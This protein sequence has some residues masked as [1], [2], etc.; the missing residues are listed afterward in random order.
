[1]GHWIHFEKFCAWYELKSNL[2]CMNIPSCPNL[3][4]T[5]ISLLSEFPTL[6]KI[7]WP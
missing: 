2:V 7:S 4:K 1:M 6:V 3:S 5:V